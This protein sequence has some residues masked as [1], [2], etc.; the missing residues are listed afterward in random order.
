M[1][2]SWS[3]ELK[4]E[5]AVEAHWHIP[6][7]EIQEGAISREDDGFKILDSQGTIMIDYLKQGRTINGTY[8]ADKLRR[9]RVEIARKRRGKL[10]EGV[11]LLHDHSPAHTS[12]VTMAAVT[13]CG[14][15]LR[16]CSEKQASW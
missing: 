13:D 15:I 8:Y 12:Q 6:S 5:H 7:E 3:G 14:F 11:L 4:T 1:T 10:T 2:T 16:T 9:L